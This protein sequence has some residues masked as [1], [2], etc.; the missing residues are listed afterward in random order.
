MNYHT[1]NPVYTK[2][3]GTTALNGVSGFSDVMTNA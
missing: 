2:R 1:N 3:C